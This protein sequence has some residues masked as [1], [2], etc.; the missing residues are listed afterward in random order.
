MKDTS[1]LKDYRE[2]YKRHYGIEFGSDFDVHHMDFD[3]SNNDI[4]NLVLLPKKLHQRYHYYLKAFWSQD[5]KSGE[6]VIKTRIDEYQ[7]EFYPKMLCGF[8]ETLREC[9][10]WL[11]KKQLMD[12]M[13]G[14]EIGD[15]QGP[16]DT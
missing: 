14:E 2:K 15:I 11:A 5:C 13:R 3:R 8:L 1:K 9:R 7:Q 6:L 4:E 10:E 16:Q 12:A